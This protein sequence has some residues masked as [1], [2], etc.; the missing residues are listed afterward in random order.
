[1]PDIFDHAAERNWSA[2]Q[3]LH[4]RSLG[5]KP[6]ALLLRYALMLRAVL[7]NAG[8]EKRVA[9]TLGISLAVSSEIGGSE[10]TCTPQP[11]RRQRA[12]PLIELRIRNGGKCW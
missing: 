2:R 3:D 11:S 10:G 5:P 7:K 8:V 12:A 4:L 9:E 6:S 1:M